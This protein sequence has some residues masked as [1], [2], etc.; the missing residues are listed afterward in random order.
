MIFVIN[1]FPVKFSKQGGTY[2]RTWVIKLSSFVFRNL[3]E[4]LT[5]LCSFSENPWGRGMVK[6]LKHFE[7]SEGWFKI[8]EE[9]KVLHFW[10]RKWQEERSNVF[11]GGVRGDQSINIQCRLFEW[12]RYYGNFGL[13]WL[14]SIFFTEGMIFSI[15]YIFLNSDLIWM[16]VIDYSFMVIYDFFLCEIEREL[17]S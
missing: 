14:V 12:L 13:K 3:G 17:E 9:L 7:D 16:K 15:Q 5:H 11:L 1:C 6:R 4:R 8:G 2:H 10:E